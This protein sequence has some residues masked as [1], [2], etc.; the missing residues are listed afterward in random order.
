MPCLLAVH[1]ALYKQM[2]SQRCHFFAGRKDY[3]KRGDSQQPLAKSW[4]CIYPNSICPFLSLQHRQAFRNE[5]K[6]DSSLPRN[7]TRAAYHLLLILSVCG[8]KHNIRV[9]S[10]GLLYVYEGLTETVIYPQSHFYHTFS[11]LQ[12]QYNSITLHKYNDRKLEVTLAG[13]RL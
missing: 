2:S 1:N 4:D 6:S 12:Q 13:P 7:L 9:V 3:S 5:V 10:Q 11:F 8:T